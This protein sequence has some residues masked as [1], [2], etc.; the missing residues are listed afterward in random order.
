MHTKSANLFIST[1][2]PCL[3]EFLLCSSTKTLLLAQMVLRCSS[4]LSSLYILPCFVFHTSHSSVYSKAMVV[5][6]RKTSCNTTIAFIVPKRDIE[7]IVV[8]TR[9]TGNKCL[10]PQSLSLCL[11]GYWKHFVLL[12]Q[13]FDLLCLVLLVFQYSVTHTADESLWLYYDWQSESNIM[14]IQ[15]KPLY[16][17]VCM[18]IYSLCTICRNSRTSKTEQKHLIYI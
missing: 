14:Y 7:N 9:H 1:V 11:K 12:P 10:A 13:V 4:S 16:T 5:A 8:S 3:S 17:S 6:T 2:N 18:C 15:Q